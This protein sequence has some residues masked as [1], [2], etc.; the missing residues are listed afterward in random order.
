VDEAVARRY[1]EVLAM[2]RRE[3]R[4]AKASDL[5]IIATARAT[6]RRLVTRDERQARLARAAGQ[7]A[8]LV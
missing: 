8:D 3:G 5:L 1:G 2:A 4:T 7:E 6:G